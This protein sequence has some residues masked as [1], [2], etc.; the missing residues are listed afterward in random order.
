[1]RVAV[2]GAAGKVGRAV[3]HE[4]KRAGHDVR[5]IDRIGDGVPCDLRDAEAAA[6]AVAGCGGIVHL[7]AWP[8]PD[9][10]PPAA[11]FNDNVAMAA[12][13][14]G[15]AARLGIRRA[16]VASS[17]SALGFAWADEVIAPDYLPVDEAHPCRPRDV[18]SLSKLVTEQIARMHALRGDL[19]PRVL[20]FPVVWDPAE[21]ESSV[22]RRLERPSQGA[23]S[24]WAY[25][26]VRDAARAVRLALE[27]ELAGFQLFN[28][29][30]PTVFA[31][32]PA[33]ELVAQFYPSLGVAAAPAGDGACF[34]WRRA[35]DGLGFV[36]R[37]RWT[38]QGIDDYPPAG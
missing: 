11:V 9:A 17:Q 2:T 8:T 12:N 37:Y 14:M 34:D 28:I 13:M 15:A 18:Y 29:T 26:D 35:R 20:R 4:L 32:V 10:A 30:A 36:C 31:T 5:P 27:A 16:V 3:V 7:A 24:Q 19:D 1:M 21:F 38:P 33:R 25:V 23:K 22:R 6:R